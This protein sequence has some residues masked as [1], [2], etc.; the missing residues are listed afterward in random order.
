MLNIQQ[1]IKDRVPVGFNSHSRKPLNSNKVMSDICQQN[2]PSNWLHSKLRNEPIIELQLGTLGGGNHFLEVLY[3]DDK[4]IEDGMQPIW[5]M[6][7][8]GSRRV[9][10][11]T[12]SYHENVGKEKYSMKGVKSPL[13]WLPIHSKDGR[14]Y[15][16]DMNWCQKYAFHSRYS[17]INILLVLQ[18]IFVLK[19][20]LFA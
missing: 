15:L 2:T 11:H 6:L 1:G 13:Y 18:L 14:N 10:N 9:G 5:L 20:H 4:D 19:F 16:Q 3:E 7:H 17:S 12:A 8:S